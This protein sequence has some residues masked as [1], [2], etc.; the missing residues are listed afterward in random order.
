MQ[1]A[2]YGAA[3]KEVESWVLLMH[4]VKSHLSAA[5]VIYT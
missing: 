2:V 5:T 1:L 4:D 3:P